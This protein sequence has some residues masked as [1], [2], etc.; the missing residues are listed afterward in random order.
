MNTA[1]LK[2]PA[3]SPLMCEDCA[4]YFRGVINTHSKYF[5]SK[6]TLNIDES[7]VASTF[8]T[9]DQLSQ[10][11]FSWPIGHACGPRDIFR[12]LLMSGW[13]KRYPQRTKISRKLRDRHFSFSGVISFVRGKVI[14]F[15][16]F[17]NRFINLRYTFGFVIPKNGKFLP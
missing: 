10:L 2:K 9:F 11:V 6:P 8:Q 5:S 3:R 17:S 15:S 14:S 13:Q 12:Y 16:E 1:A 4:R 7:G